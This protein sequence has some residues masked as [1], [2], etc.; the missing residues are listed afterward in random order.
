MESES[1]RIEEI[2]KEVRHMADQISDIKQ[3]LRQS[4]NVAREEAGMNQLFVNDMREQMLCLM[5]F[6]AKMSQANNIQIDPAQ[7]KMK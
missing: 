5:D 4:A 3:E 2:R 7:G 6:A 1:A